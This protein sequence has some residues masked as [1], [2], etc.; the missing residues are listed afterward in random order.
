MTSELAKCI[1][2]GNERCSVQTRSGGFTSRLKS[3]LEVL[4]DPDKLFALAAIARFHY[5]ST[6][7]LSEDLGLITERA[8]EIVDLLRRLGFLKRSD[9]ASTLR[10]PEAALPFLA[11]VHLHGPDKPA[12]ARTIVDESEIIQISEPQTYTVRAGDTL[13]NIGKRFYGD[14]NQYERIFRMNR[15]KLDKRNDV[16]P[17]QILTLPE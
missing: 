16:L 11:K 7:E 3:E 9:P 14:A 5:A 10:L 17:G 15:D 8:Q 2:S 1:W 4:P 12:A 6:N 13:S